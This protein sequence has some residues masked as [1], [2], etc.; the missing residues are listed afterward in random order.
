MK[1]ATSELYKADE[2]FKK[3]GND[4]KLVQ[5]TYVKDIEIIQKEIANYSDKIKALESNQK[6]IKNDHEKIKF[7]YEYEISKVTNDLKHSEEK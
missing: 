1:I 2:I 6:D 5:N 7:Q 4:T 3:I